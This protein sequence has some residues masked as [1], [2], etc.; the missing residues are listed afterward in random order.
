MQGER[1]RF[2][3][4]LQYL[5]DRQFAAAAEAAGPAL[6]FYRDLAVGAAPDGAESWANQDRLLAGVTIGAPPDPF[7]EE[8]QVWS[9][10]PP[11]PFAMA[12]EG[13]AGFSTLLAANMR[14][15]S[16]LR[17]DH[18]M[19]LQRLFLVPDGATGR[20]GAYLNYPLH[21][22]LGHLALQ[23][24]RAKCMVVGE[25]LGTVPEGLPDVLA[26]ANVLSYR[27]CCGSS[28]MAPPSPARAL[29][30]ARGG[31]R[32]HARPPDAGGVVDRRGH[33]RAPVARPA[34]CSRS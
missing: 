5:A 22:L 2:W 24:E 26:A 30:R 6:G 32:F 14:H 19:G 23:S 11:D 25:D 10:P 18:V 29:A 1:T 34:G 13:Y 12:R 7:A 28:A 31:V 27:G 8:G 17:I 15:A 3:C 20:D 9:L 16:A 33:R 4:Y 21:D